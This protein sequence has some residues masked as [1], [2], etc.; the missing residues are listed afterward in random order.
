MKKI[1]KPL[2]SIIVIITVLICGFS[3]Y[4]IATSYKSTIDFNTFLNNDNI[5]I[6]DNSYISFIPK[7]QSNS[8][9]FIFYPGGKVDPK[10]YAKYAEEIAEKGYPVFIAKMPINLAILT[11]NFGNRI[12]SENSNLVD[13]WVIGGHSLGGAMAS[14]FAY[15]NMDTVGGLVLLGAYPL[16]SVDFNNTD[17]K[18]L[19]I[20]GSLD[21]VIN[22]ENLSKTRHLLSP[23]AKYISLDGG[24]HSQF[25]YYGH[26]KGDK[27]AAITQDEQKNTTI[28]LI[29]EL[30]DSIK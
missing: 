27:Q 15:D 29:I 11:P 4:T 17:L 2:I 5:K 24:N 8:T 10:A 18:I 7:K 19:S 28:S 23:S 12:I 1:I 16:E 13:K 22:R 3:I 30:L 21:G 20:V 26:Q 9:G 25:G 6:S 14:K